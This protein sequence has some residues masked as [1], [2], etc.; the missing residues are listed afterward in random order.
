MEQRLV[1]DKASREKLIKGARITVYENQLKACAANHFW[2]WDPDKRLSNY[3]NSLTVE[4]QDAITCVDDA[5][6]H[7][8]L[9]SRVRKRRGHAC[10]SKLDPVHTAKTRRFLDDEESLYIY[11]EMFRT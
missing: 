3:W 11:K 6:T 9:W 7:E 10:F 1:T 5:K 8:L 2:S 4:A